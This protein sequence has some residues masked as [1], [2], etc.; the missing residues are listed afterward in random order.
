MKRS[1][2]LYILLL[3]AVVA[4]S[5]SS[6]NSS[7]TWGD[8]PKDYSGTAVTA[9]SL[10]SNSEVLNNL[11][12]V[13]FSIDLMNA[14]IFNAQPM[15]VGTDVSALAVSISSDA[16]S[17]AELTFFNDENVEQTIDYLKNN[18]A[19]INFSNGPVNFHIVSFDGTASR[20]Y[21]ILVNVAT[22]KADSLYWDELQ[23]GDIQA[24][25]NLRS[26]KTVKVGDKALMLSTDAQ[27]FAAISTFVPA[28]Q[29]GGGVWELPA[30][31]PTFPVNHLV[32]N[33]MTESFTSTESG[34]LFVI[35]GDGNLYRST[36]SGANFQLADAGW[37]SITAP[38]KEGVLGTKVSGATLVYASYPA[39]LLA[40][41]TAVAT[42]FPVSGVSGPA[43]ISTIWANNTQTVVTGG[44][45]IT[46]K[47]TGA[48]W[49]FDGHR[50]AK[51]S[52]KLPART[53][54]AMARYK[55]CETDTTSWRVVERDV[56]LAFGGINPESAEADE[57]TEPDKTVYISRDMGV[58]WQVASDLLQL[59]KYIPSTFGSSLLVF[60]K[61]MGTASVRPMAIT[62]ITSWNCPYLY[63]FGGSDMDGKANLKYW[64]GV[65]NHLKVKPLQ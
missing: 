58:N 53:G 51:I 41:P 2:Q 62:P 35:D 55:I 16:C 37:K 33:L 8:D 46:G 21:K 10:K 47:P 32:T 28:A 49:S 64:S 22:E 9:F 36:D 44:L 23:A 30:V 15:P 17:V 48:T 25:A 43:S 26:S 5:L 11:D 63:L 1:L 19:K 54:Y 6:C 50:W 39:S 7:E 14:S 13:F 29:T 3:P 4:C 18:E 61:N 40:S 42:D 57:E 60:E 31:S 59:P 45:T 34:D 20:D 27:G 38:Y 52:D 24:I 56:L 65:V 12:S